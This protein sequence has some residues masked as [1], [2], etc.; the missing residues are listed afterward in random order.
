MRLTEDVQMTPEWAR[1]LIEKSDAFR[2]RHLRPQQVEKWARVMRSG[3]WRLTHQGVL[4]DEPTGYVIDGQHRLHAVVATGLTVPIQITYDSEGLSKMDVIDTGIVRGAG[5]VLHIADIPY[6]QPT[7]AACRIVGQ[8]DRRVFTI[9][10]ATVMTQHEILAAVREDATRWSW[11][12]GEA[13]FIAKEFGNA[14]WRSVM[15]AG[16]YIISRD[17]TTYTAPAAW[18]RLLRSGVYE[19][20]SPELALRRWF[21]NT[22]STGRKGGHTRMTAVHMVIRAY[23]HHLAGSRLTR[24]QA[25]RNNAWV[26]VER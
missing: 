23:N 11:V 21:L 18:L 7:A 1:E 26:E 22:Y 24:L 3:D 14:G 19:P 2:N 25:P 13:E 9:N 8:Y 16:F 15:G 12:M 10:Q 5:D 4:I 6:A 20:E 17:T